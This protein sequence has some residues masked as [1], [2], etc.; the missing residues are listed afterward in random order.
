MDPYG[1]SQKEFEKAEQSNDSALKAIAKGLG[2][3]T[4]AIKNDIHS[5]QDDLADIKKKLP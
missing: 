3:L 4:W 1:D 5:I 2:L